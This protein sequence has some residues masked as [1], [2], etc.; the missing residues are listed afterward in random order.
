MSGA[1]S[2]L[3]EAV[4]ALLSADTE[5]AALLGGARVY[6]GAPRNAAAPYV[7]LGELTERDWST[8]TEPGAEVTL[9]VVA[10][11][12]QPGRAEALAIAERVQALL[13]D[14]ALAVDGFRLVS[15]RHVATETAR[16][17][18][19][20]GRRAVARFRARVEAA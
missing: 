11:S 2:A 1:A 4:F 10:W 17:E 13:H 12:R 9:A 5:L 14:A 8:A 20:A 3:Q 15:I 16:A 18:K 7:H 19:P 6:D